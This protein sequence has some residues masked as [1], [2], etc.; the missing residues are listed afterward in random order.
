MSAS[1]IYGFSAGIAIYDGLT[2]SDRR[3]MI[4]VGVGLACVGY[5]MKLNGE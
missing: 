3:W 1:V 2:D 4:L 5:F